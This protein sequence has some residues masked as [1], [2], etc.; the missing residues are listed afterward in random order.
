MLQYTNSV[1]CPIAFKYTTFALLITDYYIK[2]KME[3]YK[4]HLQDFIEYKSKLKSQPTLSHNNVAELGFVYAK[5]YELC[6]GT[7][8]E[9]AFESRRLLAVAS[10]CGVRLPA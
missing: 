5:L 6:G 3:E 2:S 10:A 7:E 4:H 9:F 8:I 1:S